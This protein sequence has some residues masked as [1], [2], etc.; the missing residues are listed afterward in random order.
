MDAYYANPYNRRPFWRER[1]D[2]GRPWIL[3][4]APQAVQSDRGRGLLRRDSP[5]DSTTALRP[6]RA[7]D[8]HLLF[9]RKGGG[10]VVAVV[11]VANDDGE[12]HWQLFLLV[13]T[14]A[15]VVAVKHFVERAG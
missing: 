11:Y 6:P 7:L 15:L 2:D 4:M 10:G 14:V 9:L 8:R 1:E 3:V 13:A 5:N 12:A